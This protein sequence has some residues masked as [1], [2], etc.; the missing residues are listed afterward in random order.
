M[1]AGAAL[2]FEVVGALMALTAG[3]DDVLFLYFGRVSLVAVHAGYLGFMGT[4][5]AGNILRWLVVAF[6]AVFGCEFR[7]IHSS[8]KKE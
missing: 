3:G 2:E 5:I 7:A 4:A 8:G 1:A 6:D